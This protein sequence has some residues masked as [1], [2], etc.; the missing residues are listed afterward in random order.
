MENN[1]LVFKGE[2]SQAQTNSLLVAEK[3]CKRHADVIR[4]IEKL[5]D[6]EDEAL[7]AKMRLALSQQV[8]L[9]RQESAI[10]CMQ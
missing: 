8:T 1:E 4:S 2:N 3:F 5:L 7:N 10:R 6:T 9:I